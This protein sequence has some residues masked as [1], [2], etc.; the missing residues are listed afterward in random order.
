VDGHEWSVNTDPGQAGIHAFFTQVPSRFQLLSIASWTTSLGEFAPPSANSPAIEVHMHQPIAQHPFKCITCEIGI[1][2]QPVVHL[3][4]TFCCA[5]CV[6]GGPCICSY[7]KV[8]LNRERPGDPI[9]SVETAMA[10]DSGGRR[11]VAVVSVE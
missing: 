2:G 8:A 11:I 3:G 6:A 7:D 4:L 5:G 10:K 9:E 1:V